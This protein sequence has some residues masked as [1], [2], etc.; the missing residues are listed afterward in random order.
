MEKYT[1]S[2]DSKNDPLRSQ[3]GQLRFV[4]ENVFNYAKNGLHRNGYFVDLAAAHPKRFSNTFFL[5]KKLGWRGILIDANPYFTKLLRENRT[6][7]VFECAI[8]SSNETLVDFRIDN[9]ELGGIVGDAFDNSYSIRGGELKS[10]KIIK[11]KTRTLESILDEANAPA[12]IDYLSLDIEGAEYE[13][14]KTFDFSKYRFRC[15]TVE[16][17]PLDLDL[18]LDSHGYVQVQHSK[19]DTFYIHKSQISEACLDNCN[20]HFFATPAKDW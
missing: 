12:V 3:K 18:L 2:P 13:A 11:V 1:F 16:C 8:T 4:L 20:P 17:P 15:M 19:Y 7:Q 14:L 10:A 6:S 9:G 5:E